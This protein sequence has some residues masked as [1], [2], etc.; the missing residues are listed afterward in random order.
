MM[1][2]FEVGGKI[3]ISCDRCG[4]MLPVDLWDEF[5]ILV[6]LAE[7]PQQMNEQEEIPDVYYIA[8]GESH[9]DV[10]DW[11]YEFINLNMH[12]SECAG[13]IRWGASM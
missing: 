7:D 4:N 3:D 8:R 9:I 13:K 10:A 6:K 5:N 2:K 12:F 1:L 11:I